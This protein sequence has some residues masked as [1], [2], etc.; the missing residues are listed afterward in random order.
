MLHLCLD[1]LTAGSASPPELASLAAAN[2][3][4]RISLPLRSLD[5]REP[6]LIGDTAM[7]RETIRRCRAL[8]VEIDLIEG[9][10][11][12]PGAPRDDI[13]PM[14]AA[15]AALDAKGANVVMRGEE[16]GVVLDQAARLCELAKSYDIPVFFEFSRRMT[17]K[18]LPEAAEFL[19]LLGADNAKVLI[20][21]LHFFRFGGAAAQ[22]TLHRDLIGRA[23]LSDGPLVMPVEEQLAEAYYERLLPGEGELPL[24]DL[25]RALPDGVTVGAEVPLRSWEERGVSLDER[26]RRVLAAS[27]TMLARV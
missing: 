19:R 25:L 16:I 15:G 9:F 3:C 20:D 17:I 1:F 26:V 18:T 8:G 27:A 13:E 2:G 5:G 22:V 12:K 24:L 7:R 4:R 10:E 23:Q 14:L 11:L 6:S 21:T